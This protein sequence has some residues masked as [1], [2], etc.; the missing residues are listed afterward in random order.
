MT[1]SDSR[2]ER[3]A[4]CDLLARLGPDQ[5]TL[6]AGWQT[7]DLAAHL[8]VRERRP[9]AAGGFAFSRLASYADRVQGEIARRPFPE[10][11]DELRRPPRW[12]P[13]RLGWVD[14]AINSME[15]FIHHEDV[16]R[17]QPQWQPR[18]LPQSLADTLWRRVRAIARFR[19][20]RFPAPVVV[21]SQGH[22]E[23]RTGRPGPEPVQLTGDPG[24]LVIF[25][26]G[27]QTHSQVTVAGPAP[28][29]ARITSANLG[30]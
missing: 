21:V 16:R 28:L 29:T 8:L 2:R 9:L 12:A 7:Q 15:M 26:S 10:L 22:G 20:R 17:A 24:E 18:P 30:L 11:V 19:L 14:G 1:S 23:L 27:R 4:L 6:C 3:A 25:L 13:T 5:P